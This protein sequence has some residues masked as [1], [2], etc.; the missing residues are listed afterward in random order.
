MFGRIAASQKDLQE[1]QRQSKGAHELLS[2]GKPPHASVGSVEDQLGCVLLLQ[3]NDAEAL[4][5]LEKALAT[6]QLIEAGKRVKSGAARVKW[7]MF[8]VYENLGRPL[9]AE[10]FKKAAGDTKNKLL[11]T[12]RYPMG[13]GEE[14]EYDSLVGLL[15]R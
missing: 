3:G 10:A 15:F 11:A 13:E 12:G 9:H 6:C 2:K 8:Q 7:R 14:R 4:E 5:H 1:A